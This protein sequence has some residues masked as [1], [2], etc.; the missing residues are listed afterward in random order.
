MYVCPHPNHLHNL[1]HLQVKL[2]LNMYMHFHANI[3]TTVWLLKSQKKWCFF[4]P[5]C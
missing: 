3:Q 2:Y 1:I 5:F 4:D